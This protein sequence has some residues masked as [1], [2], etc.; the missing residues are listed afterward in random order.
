MTTKSFITSPV[1]LP[2]GIFASTPYNEK[3]MQLLVRKAQ[4]LNHLEELKESLKSQGLNPSYYE[5]DEESILCWFDKQHISNSI[6]IWA[7]DGE[8]IWSIAD[9]GKLLD[10]KEFDNLD[11][12]LSFS[13]V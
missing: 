3:A 5:S 12:F 11:D 1:A 2:T 4:M 6:S 7:N 10:S 8:G 9:K 13:I